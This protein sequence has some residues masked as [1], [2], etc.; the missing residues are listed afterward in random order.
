AEY[1]FRFKTLYAVWG[2]SLPG[3][4]LSVTGLQVEVTPDTMEQ[5]TSTLT[6]TTTCNLT[7]D[8]TLTYTWYKNG[9]QLDKPTSFQHFV[10][11]YNTDRYSC[12]VSGVHS[13]AVCVLG[14]SCMAVTYFHQSICALK[15]SSIN[16]SCSFKYPSWHVVKNIT[17]F[18]RW[19]TGVT[20]N[21]SQDPEY[22]GRVE[23]HQ[24]TDK[25]S[26]LRITD[27]RLTDSAEYKFR[28]TTNTT[29]WGYSYPGTTLTVTDLKVS[30]ATKDG[31]VILSC[32][33]SC[34][35]TDKPS[36]IWYKNGQRLTNINNSLYLGPVIEDAGYSCAVTGHDDLR[37]PEET[38]TVR[39]FPWFP[40]VVG[41]AVLTAAALSLTIY[42]TLRRRCKGG[43]GT[44]AE[45]QSVHSDTNNGD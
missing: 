43:S 39:L 38:L 34:T 1:K 28:F 31:K 42:C 19:E 29:S 8:S 26:T 27:L 40:V 17:W 22:A 2:K 44:T 14:Q 3:S 9:Q 25:D 20:K 12:A 45:T 4:T 18:K 6:C 37:S 36:Y 33:T 16:I 30:P 23:Y 35:L 13:P 10:K 41:G 24:T 7:N 21:V 32:S 15:G 11:L 5:H